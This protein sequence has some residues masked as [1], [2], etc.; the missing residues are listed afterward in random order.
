MYIDSYI[1]TQGNT[2]KCD[3]KIN[4]IAINE[5]SDYI[6]PSIRNYN[7]QIPRSISNDRKQKLHNSLLFAIVNELSLPITMKHCSLVVY[8]KKKHIFESKGNLFWFLQTKSSINGIGYVFY[9][10]Q[11][12]KTWNTNRS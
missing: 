11:K 2:P 8:V 9:S 3:Y 10:V 12:D 5:M 1:F 4:K 7:F 6:N